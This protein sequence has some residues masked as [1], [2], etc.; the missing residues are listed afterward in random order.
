MADVGVHARLRAEWFGLTA[1][2]QGVHEIGRQCE[3]AD[4]ARA[5]A[6]D[7]TL[8]S[9]F[10]G[11]GKT[12]L[13]RHLLAHSGERRLA[14]VVNDFGELGFDAG[15]IRAVHGDVIELSNGCSC[16]AMG[17]DFAR[18]LAQLAGR[19]S[20]PDAIVVEASGVADP[21][22]LAAA[23]LVCPLTRLAGIV[24][25][26]DGLAYPG[27]IAD[28]GAGPLL[29][30]QIE[31]AHLIALT[32][33]D[34]MSDDRVSALQAQIGRE[35]PGRRVLAA[36]HG[37][38]DPALVLQASRFGARPAPSGASHD[39][40]GF[41]A[42]TV[43]AASPV[44]EQALAAFLAGLPGGIYRIKG[45]LVLDAGD[46]VDFQWAGGRWRFEACVPGETAELTVIGVAADRPAWLAGLGRACGRFG[47][48]IAGDA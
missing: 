17:A 31:A 28:P 9:G 11:A 36:A 8:L 23:V 37:V 41:H 6:V 12:T 4:R 14:V 34:A 15:Q 33:T 42:V 46:C 5:A 47:W 29:R 44:S 24:T 26:I 45:H 30:R 1:A 27:A 19:E 13:L 43:R 3:G 40:R 22:A 7:V 32:R 21:N 38:I 39:A 10:L 48:S 16:C 25:V 20:A 18:T 35:H 2:L